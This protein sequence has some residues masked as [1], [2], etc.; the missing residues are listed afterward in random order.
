M[1][2][3]IRKWADVTRIARS[4]SAEY[5]APPT[6]QL[7]RVACDQAEQGLASFSWVKLVTNV[8]IFSAS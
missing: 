8:S 7:T 2:G 3:I 4:T 5:H 1:N 6:H